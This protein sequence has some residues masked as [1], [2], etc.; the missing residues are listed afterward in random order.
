MPEKIIGRVDIRLANQNLTRDH[1]LAAEG[2]GEKTKYVI[3]I[4]PRV[5]EF[6][7]FRRRIRREIQKG[8]AEILLFGIQNRAPKTMLDGIIEYISNLAGVG[9]QKRV[10]NFR[11]VRG[12]CWEDEDPAVV[13]EFL[14]Y[15]EG[16]TEGF[17]GRLNQAMREGR[18]DEET[19]DRAL[20]KP[21]KH[22]C[23]SFHSSMVMKI[24]DLNSPNSACGYR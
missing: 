2:V 8:M 19:L 23:E 4:S 9:P 6:S 21:A 3:F 20:G 1:I 13:A 11:D 18:W 16:E 22:L 14:G 5:M 10:F 7:D 24:Q 15:C 17:I 12:K